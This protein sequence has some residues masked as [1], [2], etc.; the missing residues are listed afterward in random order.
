MLEVEAGSARAGG[1]RSVS[2]GT[3]VKHSGAGDSV[4][5]T[6]AVMGPQKSKGRVRWGKNWHMKL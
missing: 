6:R 1:I 5:A 2:S 4:R 3:T